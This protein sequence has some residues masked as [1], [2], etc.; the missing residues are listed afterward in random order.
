[1][2]HTIIIIIALVAFNKRL[3]AQ[4][5]V[6]TTGSKS[7]IL[8]GATTEFAGVSYENASDRFSFNYKMT[9][10]DKLEA[11]KNF[12]NF[13]GL[14]IGTGVKVDKG[15]ANLLNDEKWQ[16]GIDFDLTFFRTWDNTTSFNPKESKNEV[17]QGSAKIISQQTFFVKLSNSLE[18]FK[19]FESFGINQD[20]TFISLDNPLQN[21]FTITPGY[22]TMYQFESNWYF[23]YALS[24]NISFIK[25][26]T[27]KLTESTL[28]PI[29][30]NV[31]NAK[32]S[33]HIFETAK[34]ESYFSGKS[35]FETFYVPRADVFLRYSLGE[36]Y[37]V[38]GLLASY[39]LMIS[40]FETVKNRNCIA[41]GPTFGL[42]TFPDHVV[43]AIMNEFVEDKNG[44]FKYALTFQASFP[45]KFK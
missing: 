20:T 12:P 42:D 35:E 11:G 33:S 1:M 13:W 29:S 5:V 45:I 37:P 21:N 16:G 4:S 3:N 27:R 31:L 34:Q 38:I 19:S 10:Q 22:Y 30:G 28:V 44:D 40:S 14:N 8:V 43:F 2:K 17:S 32:D 15:K 18:R 36:K 25:N 7:G 24:T 23:S 39:S 6:S 41:I 9:A 26:S